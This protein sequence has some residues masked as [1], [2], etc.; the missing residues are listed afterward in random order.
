MKYYL[1]LIRPINLIFIVVFYA[2][3]RYGFLAQQGLEFA[4]TNFNYWLF[5]LAMVCIAAAG[6]VIND[7]MDYEADVINKPKK[8]IIKNHISEKMAYLYIG[9]KK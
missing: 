6:Y 5:I 4:L 7:I 8:V 1:L 9:I 3:I 2:L